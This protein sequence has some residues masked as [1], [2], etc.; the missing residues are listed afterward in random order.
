MLSYEAP[1]NYRRSGRIIAEFF[2]TISLRLFTSNPNKSIANTRRRG[3]EARLNLCTS[4]PS[5]TALDYDYDYRRI[6][7][8]V[9]NSFLF[10]STSFE[11]SVEEEAT[12]ATYLHTPR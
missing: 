8:P 7:A 4:A 10:S 11:A 2:R 6:I 1:S 12:S 9:D 3:V 5:L